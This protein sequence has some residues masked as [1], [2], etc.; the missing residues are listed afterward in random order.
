MSIGAYQR[1]R[2]IEAIVS[3]QQF[4]SVSELALTIG[5]SMI[6]VRRDIQLLDATHRVRKIHGGALSI[7]Q[8]EWEPASTAS[9][10][11]SA[12]RV[13]AERAAAF[14]EPKTSVAVNAGP[15]SVQVAREL[16]Q[17][18]GLTVVTNSLAVANM[19]EQAVV[20]R[21]R[22]WAELILT[23]GSQSASGALVGP[24]A[25]AALA[26]INPAVLF[27]SVDGADETVGL[28]TNDV[29]EAEVNR[30]FIHSARQRVA[31]VPGGQWGTVALNVIAKFGG[32]EAL[33]TDS[34]PDA[35]PFPRLVPSNV[36]LVRVSIDWVKAVQ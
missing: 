11:D 35:A 7:V 9:M 20:H 24:T 25:I 26:R 23:G 32:V 29:L 17:I 8:D 21:G 28:S 14:A 2:D 27:L 18:E 31:V 10:N 3:R 16:M 34:A 12:W 15:G 13:I 33:V 6:T 4:A 36:E 22:G 1:R 5:S 30:A 19:V